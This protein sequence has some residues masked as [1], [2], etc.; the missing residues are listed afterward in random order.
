MRIYVDEL[1]GYDVVLE[2]LFVEELQREVPDSNKYRIGAGDACYY[3]VEA[4]FEKF[5]LEAA[6][7]PGTI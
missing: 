7:Q 1:S 5:A 6:G 3:F 4:Y 2:R